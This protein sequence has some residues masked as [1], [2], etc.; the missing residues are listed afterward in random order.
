MSLK[1]TV[2]ARPKNISGENGWNKLLV[3]L[4]HGLIIIVYYAKK[5]QK[6]ILY[7]HNERNIHYK[8]R[9]AKN[10]T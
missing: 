2:K 8:T 10:E 3:T 6:H 4:P 9:N 5:V 1:F 7:T